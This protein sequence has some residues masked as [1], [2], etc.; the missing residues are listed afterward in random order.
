MIQ[1]HFAGKKAGYEDALANKEK[2]V[3]R[4]I[5]YVKAVIIPHYASRFI[6]G[7]EQGFRAGTWEREGRERYAK[8][9][10]TTSKT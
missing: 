10:K 6:K 5:S 4:H 2:G 9:R 7:Y 3:N 8:Q 1:A